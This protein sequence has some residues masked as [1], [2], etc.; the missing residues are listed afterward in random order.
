M[1]MMNYFP[2]F[3]AAYFLDLIWGDPVWLLHPVKVI[4]GLIQKLELLL[5]RPG[6]ASEQKSAGIVLTGVISLGVFIISAGLL[7]LAWKFSLYLGLLLSIYLG[8]TCISVRDMARHADDIYQNLLDGDIEG[9]RSNTAKIVGRDTDGLSPS[10]ICRAAVESIAESTVDGIISPLFYLFIGGPVIGPALVLFYKAV[11]TLDSMVGYCNKKYLN[12][13][14]ASAKLD[15]ILNYLPSR[16]TRFIMPVAVSILGKDGRGAF[17]LAFDQAGNH[18][19]PN[20]GIPEAVMAG[21]LGIRLGG[22]NYYGGQKSARPF[23]GE[24]KRTVCPED[25]RS[26]VKIMYGTSF[27]MIFMEIFITAI[28]FFAI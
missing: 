21:A 7:V 9:A 5:L 12:F 14:W 4:G 23:M 6:P 16:I 26:A 28:I 24:G 27:L 10:D 20:S 13:G 22:V 1:N 3:L 19:S 8:Y 17:R 25:I 11:S 18:P 15:D 2:V